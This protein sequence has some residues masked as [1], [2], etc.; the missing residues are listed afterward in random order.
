MP[1]IDQEEARRLAAE[2]LA[3]VKGPMLGT[4]LF[5][6][7]MRFVA[8]TA[9]ELCLIRDRPD[10]TPEVYIMERP[11]GVKYQLEWH[12]PGCYGRKKG[13]GETTKQQLRRLC[14]QE[15]D[16]ARVHNAVQIGDGEYFDD[17]RGYGR[18]RIF[19]ATRFQNPPE[20]Q[21]GRWVTLEELHNFKMVEAHERV[22]IPGAIGY[23][24]WRKLLAPEFSS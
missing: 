2:A 13:K 10:G 8:P 17:Q 23:Y 9:M 21:N 19:V 1:P 6:Q 3:R 14:K 24:T 7:V 16:G 4:T 18:S 15:L 20:V 12:V 22:I 11:P 5:D